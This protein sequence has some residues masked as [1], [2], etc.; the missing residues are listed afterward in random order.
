MDTALYR[1]SPRWD[2]ER[3]SRELRDHAHGMV[4]ATLCQ[5]AGTL[6]TF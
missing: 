2:V 6:N 1:Y 3:M 5:P 4:V